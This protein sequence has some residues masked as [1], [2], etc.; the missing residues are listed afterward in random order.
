MSCELCILEIK[1]TVYYESD[2]FII[3]DCKDCLIPMAVWKR[4]KMKISKQGEYV[5]REMLK[6]K[7][8]EFYGNTNFYIDVIQRKVLDHLHWHAREYEV[9]PKWIQERESV[10]EG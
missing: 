8:K 5:M 6:I 10:D 7:A 2:Y 4:H 1:T 9:R 3:L